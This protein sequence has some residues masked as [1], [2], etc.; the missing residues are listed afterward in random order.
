MAT[1]KVLSSSADSMM[2]NEGSRGCRLRTSISVDSESADV[3][4]LPVEVVTDSRQ[5]P[6]SFLEP[7]EFEPITIGFDCEGVDLARHGQLC[8]MQLAWEDKVYLVDVVVG[9]RQLVEGCR[10]GLESPFVTKVI[11]DCKRDSE[12]LYFQFGIRLQGVF[13]TQVAYCMIEKSLDD[14]ISFVY[15]LADERYCGVVYEEKQE[16]REIMRK[17]LHFWLHRPWTPLM[18]RAASDDVRF[19]LTI[20]KR[21]LAKIVADDEPGQFYGE[22]SLEA[23]AKLRERQLVA[24]CALHCRCFCLGA[25]DWPPVPLTDENGLI[26]EEILAIVDVPP[27]MMGRVIGKKGISIRD[28]KENCREADIITG[29][30]KGPHDKVFVIG[31]VREVRKAEA[32]IRGKFDVY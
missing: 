4:P 18:L 24:R 23:R 22:G 26:E 31:P 11:H 32:I 29:G 14:G 27:G 20:H 25:Y 8:I 5:L 19:L 6:L 3:T 28:I 15:L 16:V 7:S 1:A 10:K 17:D 21:M 30:K 12:A 13:D 2:A 9:G